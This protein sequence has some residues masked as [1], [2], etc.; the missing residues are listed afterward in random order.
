MLLVRSPGVLGAVAGAGFLL[1]LAVASRPVFLGSAGAAA[2][3]SDIR[4]GCRYEIGMRVV[5]GRIRAVA[6]PDEAS[7]A[8]IAPRTAQL[9]AATR[10]DGVQPVI[11]TVFGGNAELQTPQGERGQGVVQLFSRNGAFNHVHVRSR[12]PDAEAG[13]WVPDTTAALLH[14]TA[15]DTMNVAMGDVVVPAKVGAVFDDLTYVERPK[16]WCSLHR[17]FEPLGSNPLPPVAVA[18]QDVLVDLMQR[19]GRIPPN[20]WWEV[21]PADGLSV[22]RAE[23]LADRLDPIFDDFQNN[24][25]FADRFNFDDG[26]NVHMALGATLDHA[27][28]VMRQV[29]TT[30]DTVGAAST[31]IALVAVAAAGFFW[32][33][34]R[35]AEV[36]L[37]LAKG[38]G[39][40]ALALKG[41]LESVLPLALGSMAG[42]GTAI[43]A[44][45]S[46]GPSDAFDNLAAAE[47]ARLA[48]AAAVVGLVLL[49]GAA[50]IRV[51]RAE[52][53]MAGVPH[54]RRGITPVVVAA[55][56]VTA[57]VS[58]VLIEHRAGAGLQSVGLIVVVFP[59]L[60]LVGGGGLIAVAGHWLLPRTRR[61]AG[62]WPTAPYL[63]VRRVATA[64]PLALALTAGS[65]LSVGILL[66]AS[67]VAE[68]ARATVTAKAGIGVGSDMAVFMPSEDVP[69]LPADIERRSTPILRTLASYEEDSRI[70]VLALDTRTFPRAA[71]YDRTFAG[72]TSLGSLLKKLD[73]P[74]R[75]AVPVI[76]ADAADVPDRFTADIGGIEVP[77]RVVA[78]ATAF[79]GMSGE[80]P[81]LVAKESA[82]RGHGVRGNRQIWVKGSTQSVLAQLDRAHVPVVTTTEAKFNEA[83]SSLL[84]LA[85]SL[86]Y[87]K[88]LGLLGGTVTLCGAVFY[89]ASRERARRLAGVM[90]K[91]MGLTRNASR[92][93]LALELG[94]LLLLGLALGGGLSS[95][96]AKVTF[97]HLDP[98]PGTPPP[99]IFRWDLA[100]LAW[101]ALVTVAAAGALALL[102]ERATS[103]RLAAEVVRDA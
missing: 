83:A 88:A 24:G 16:F 94:G 68:S 82:L 91:G 41:A 40:G 97:P 76:V 27:H 103:R 7:I 37:L 54:H 12:A 96:A 71:L 15:G 92:A 20:V 80:Q 35:R 84:P 65:V 11:T 38:V 70:D 58:A 45:H 90:A 13:I 10:G 6:Q 59:L 9:A 62:R 53:R 49:G 56:A 34:R 47:G 17:Q 64:G 102:S 18:R 21:P 4:D 50:G 2:V 74:T 48:L 14:V 66:Y 22:P 72:G 89:L 81:L 44:V 26:L 101:T 79:P 69:T 30:A 60:V 29:R 73:G 67:V 99:L 85:T 8:R 1:T 42:I 87:F 77:V 55:L 93:A 32:V 86:G 23:A 52:Q 95:W 43:A 78:R 46:F 75:G 57:I 31:A 5:A 25:P 61:M 98:S 63:A 3:E 39:P 28:L 36:A 100:A 51:S 19:T 33:D